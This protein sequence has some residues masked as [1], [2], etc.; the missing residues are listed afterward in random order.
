[1]VERKTTKLFAVTPGAPVIPEVTQPSGWTSHM[2]KN[3]LIL[4]VGPTEFAETRDLSYHEIAGPSGKIGV[5]LLAARR[6]SDGLWVALKIVTQSGC[7]DKLTRGKPRGQILGLTLASG[8]FLYSG[9]PA[10]SADNRPRVYLGE[11]GEGK[12]YDAIDHK[13]LQWVNGEPFYPASEASKE[14]VVHGRE[15][16]ERF[17]EIEPPILFVANRP[18]YRARL[19]EKKFL[20]WGTEKS[21]PC[22]FI[23]PP[24]WTGKEIVAM[25]TDGVSKLQRLS[26][27]TV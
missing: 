13:Q 22:D 11:A 21:K 25:A 20:V 24:Q 14:F 3:L 12:P 8:E 6:Q 2:M 23:S 17:D 1:M 26:I 27:K 7:C 18:N 4:G 15:E 5:F 16:G 10:K 19:G 9:W